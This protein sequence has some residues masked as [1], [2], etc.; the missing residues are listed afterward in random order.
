MKVLVVYAH[1]NPQSFNHAILEAFT[2][3]LKDGGHTFEVVDLHAI[4]FDP[5]TKLEDLAQF[6]G[7]QMPRD[8]LEQQEKL[9]AADGLAAICQCS[10]MVRRR[11]ASQ[12]TSTLH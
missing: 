1:P 2:K 11:H 6:T 8:V 3:G 7:G 5:C 12:G 10:H 9:A 4:K